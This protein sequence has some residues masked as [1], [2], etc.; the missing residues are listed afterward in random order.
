MRGFQPWIPVPWAIRFTH[1]H[2]DPQPCHRR[3]GARTNHSE[4]PKPQWKHL[5]NPPQQKAAWKH[6][7]VCFSQSYSYMMLYGY[8]IAKINTPGRG[9]GFHMEKKHLKNIR[10]KK[11]LGVCG[12]GA[13]TPLGA[14]GIATRSL[15]KDLHMSSPVDRCH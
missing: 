7:Y 5:R 10:N 15:H 6:R 4:S 14:P 3:G 9:K 2:S 13:R 1:L 8:N 12:L 11:L